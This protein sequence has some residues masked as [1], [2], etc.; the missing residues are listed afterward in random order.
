MM[1]GTP[2]LVL[3]LLVTRGLGFNMGIACP[4]FYEL[5]SVVNFGIRPLLDSSMDLINATEPEKE[6]VKKAQDCFIDT[7]VFSMFNHAIYVA[8]IMLSPDCATFAADMLE[9]DASEVISTL[10][11]LGR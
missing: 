4:M 7:G 9:Q 8:G 5:L 6:A 1:K 2:L 10:L 11:P 3:A